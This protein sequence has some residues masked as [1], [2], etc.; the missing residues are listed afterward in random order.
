M[1]VTEGT[2]SLVICVYSC[3]DEF[4]PRLMSCKN[5]SF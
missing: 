3:K 4:D 1:I 2:L 5:F